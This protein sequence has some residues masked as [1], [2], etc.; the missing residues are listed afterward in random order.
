[1]YAHTPARKPEIKIGLLWHSLNSDNL[2]I[3]AMTLGHIAMVEEVAAQLGLAVRFLLLGWADP[4][5]YYE[6][7]ERR[8]RA[9]RLSDFA[10]VRSGFANAV[11]E[12]DVVL[13]LGA[14]DR[15][16]ISRRQF[17][18]KDSQAQ[19]VL[20]SRRRWSSATDHRTVRARL[21]KRL[22]LAVCAVPPSSRRGR[23]SAS[24]PGK[25]GLLNGSLKPRTSRC[26][27]RIPPQ[28]PHR[29]S[30]R[31][32]INVSGL[33][34][35]GGYTR[36]NMFRPQR[37]LRRADALDHRILSRLAGVKHLIGHVQSENHAV[38]D[39]QRAGNALVGNS[40]ALSWLKPTR[41]RRRPSPHTA[42]TLMAVCMRASRRSPPAC[43]SCR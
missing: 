37:R 15:F 4:R 20:L 26:G 27:C 11:R 28:A 5:P 29:R 33:L 3:G 21:D 19:L 23:T 7:R 14:G 13:D 10:R 41:T 34:C 36:D 22:A 25:W 32:G 38:D 24:M 16:P 1:M 40:P 6:P 12:C 31:V 30:V 2:G 39:D 18:R 17:R 9:L 43:Q 35:N 8:V 42:W